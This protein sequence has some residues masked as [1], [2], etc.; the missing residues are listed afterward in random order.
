MG[1]DSAAMVRLKTARAGINVP[2]IRRSGNDRVYRALLSIFLL[3]TPLL[4]QSPRGS[5]R[6]KVQDASGARIPSAEVV[7]QS[8][9][10]AMRREGQTEDRGEFRIDDLPAG[11]YHIT[12]TASGFADARA[13]VSIA[14]SSVREITVRLKLAASAQSITV[15]S[16]NSS[17]TTQQIDL[18]RV[19]H[20]GVIGVQDLQTLP[21]A[22][23]SF[24]NIAYLAPGTETVEPSAHTT[25]R[26]TDA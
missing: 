4:A 23:R 17:L 2:A 10:S 18:A 13:D 19:V 8:S 22:Q 3:L 21:L 16:Q 15:Q 14:V 7:V 24:A 6:G 12:V 5:L 1:S 25:E 26:I 9:D 20:P 11:T